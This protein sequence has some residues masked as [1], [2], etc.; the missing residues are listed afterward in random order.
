MPSIE[1]QYFSVMLGI[2]ITLNASALIMRSTLEFIMSL[3]GHPGWYHD[4]RRL[5]MEKQSVNDLHASQWNIFHEKECLLGSNVVCTTD[6]TI[7]LH[8]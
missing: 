7:T 8:I 2:V 3:L 5:R 4:G 6:I 1:G